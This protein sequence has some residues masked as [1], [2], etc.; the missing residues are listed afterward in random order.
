MQAQAHVEDTASS[1]PDH[2]DGADVTMKQVAL[3]LLV[4]D[5]AF[6]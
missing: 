2:R 3:S 5:L 1:A 6:S 4:E